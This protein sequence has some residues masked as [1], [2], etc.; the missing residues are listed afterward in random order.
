MN[1][2]IASEARYRQR[3]VKYSHKHG[4]TQ[5]G[6]RFHRSRQAIYEWRVKWDGSWKSLVERSH[7]PHSHPK[8]HTEEEKELVLRHYARNKD[9]RILL[10][11]TLREKGYTRQYNSMNRALARWIGEEKRKEAKK[12][13]KPYQRADYPGQKVQIDV[14]YVPM[15]CVTNGVQYYQFT[16]VD[17]CSRWAF[18][19]MYDERSTYSAK[20]FLMKLIETAPFPIRLAQTDN[21]TE[22]TNALLVTKAKHK[23][24]FEQALLDMDILYQRIRIATPRHNGKVE[25]QHRCD[26]LRF[27]SKLRMYNLA[28]GRKQLAAY[29]KKS[30]GIFK[31]CL[32]FQSPNQLLEKYLAVM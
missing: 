3:V 23:S 12:Q 10:W 26:D 11:Q 30:N 22:F 13:P 25:R 28:D 17:E 20:D 9:D 1:Q 2:S 27:Y 19:E 7:R 16:A 21:G 5:A 18:R 14:K 31:I 24:L 29:N 6:I 15:I 8:Q 4:V 32:G